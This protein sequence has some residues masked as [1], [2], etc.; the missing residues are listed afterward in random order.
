MRPS[1]TYKCPTVALSSWENHGVGNL[2]IAA[3]LLELMQKKLIRRCLYV[4]P[5]NNSRFM[6]Y[7]IESSIAFGVCEGTMFATARSGAFVSRYESI[8]PSHASKWPIC[9]IIRKCLFAFNFKIDYLLPVLSLRC[10]YRENAT[11]YT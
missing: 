5:A 7:L 8:R 2:P 4:Y 1:S 9:K 10:L 3:A 6:P 11:R